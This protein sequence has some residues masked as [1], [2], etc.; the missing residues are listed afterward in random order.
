M[1]SIKNL[2][3]LSY[4]S[5]PAK[6]I[7]A[8]TAS[9]ISRRKWLERVSGPAFGATLGMWAISNKSDAAPANTDP[10]S[11]NLRGARVYNIRDFGAIGDGKTL[12]TKA[13]Q[14][15]IDACTLDD[16]GTV[17]IPAGTFVTGTIQLKS[18]VRLYI[19]AKG[20]LQGTGDGKQYYAADAIPLTGDSTLNDGNVGLFFAV[21][22]D[23]ITIEGPGTIDGQGSQFRSA[24]KGELPPAGISGPHRP[25]HLLFYQCNNLTVRD[26]YLLNSAFH[27]VRVIQSQFVKMEGLHIRGRVIQ[28]NDGF[29]FISC[30]YVH[31]NNCDVQSQDD[32]CALFGSCKFVTVVNCSFSTR[33]SVFRFG[34]GEAE[35][36]TVCNCIIYEAYGCPIKLHCSPGSRFEN[37]SFSNIIMKDVTGPISIGIRTQNSQPNA[38]GSPPGIVRNIS[39]SGITATVVKPVPLR[40]TEHPSNYN[41]GEVFSSV[42]LN[43]MDD[44]YMENI[45]FNNVQLTFPG[46]GTIEQGAVRDVPKVAGEYYQMGIPPA[47]GL[48]ARNVKGLILHNVSLS[49]ANADMRP[50]LILDNVHDSA[51]NSLNIDGNE[52]AESACR[53]IN[54]EDILLTAVR[55]KNRG[56]FF[57]AVEG[58]R[59]NAI[60]IDGGDISKA[61]TAVSFNKGALKQAVKLRG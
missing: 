61:V 47:Y 13:I 38:A 21:K 51:I 43:A 8:E 32:A 18:N 1:R 35:N 33:W 55:L 19:A 20:I 46:G 23:N 15:A 58:E 48:F 41:P 40:D 34:G 11:D 6:Q 42:T 14:A 49:V 2:V 17:L 27:S 16:G 7:K 28:N 57:L 39:F 5:R 30:S 10:K 36:I 54:S 60:T 9:S 59:S 31:I 45:T 37:M 26:I 53:F 4:F 12:N 22:A 29:H 3:G 56:Q 50:A 52:Q 24:K 25:Y 44:V